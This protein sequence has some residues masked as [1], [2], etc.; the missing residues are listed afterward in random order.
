MSILKIGGVQNKPSSGQRCNPLVSEAN[1][2]VANLTER[3]KHLFDAIQF[4]Y[5]DNDQII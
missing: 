4:R 3:K 2:E 1:R 5:L